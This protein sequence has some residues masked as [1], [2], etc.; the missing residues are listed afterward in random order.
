MTSKSV[1]ALLVVGLLTSA[2][3]VLPP[4]IARADVPPI[5]V[6][7]ACPASYELLSVVALEATGP[8]RGPRATDSAGNNNGYVCGLQ[9]PDAVR[10]AYCDAILNPGEGVPARFLNACTM[11]Q[12]GLPIYIFVDDDN[13][14]AQEAS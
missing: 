14:A 3:A 13:P 8:Y 5:P 11:K 4:G 2:G 9:R 10:D 12:L 7:T 1:R 6:T